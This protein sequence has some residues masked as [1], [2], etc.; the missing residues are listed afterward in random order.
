MTFTSSN[1]VLI[2]P[3]KPNAI[4]RG[5]SMKAKWGRDITLFEQELAALREYFQHE[6][7]LKAQPW[8][9][10]KPDEV[11]KLSVPGSKALAWRDSR[12]KF[13]VVGPNGES[14]S[15][16]EDVLASLYA[17][18]YDYFNSPDLKAVRLKEEE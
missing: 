17:M 18:G 16:A 2:E 7:K 14:R 5:L 1:E 8:L 9:D 12:G 13:T 11:W 4:S 15:G 3:I 6:E 10:A